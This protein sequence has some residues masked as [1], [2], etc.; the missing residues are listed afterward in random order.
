MAISSGLAK[1]SV[2]KWNCFWTTRTNALQS[3]T[4]DY[5]I[6]GRT[7]RTKKF[8]SRSG[9]GVFALA[10]QAGRRL[11]ARFGGDDDWASETGKNQHNLRDQNFGAACPYKQKLICSFLPKKHN[12]L[13]GQLLRFFLDRGMRLV[14]LH[15]AIRFKSLPYIASYIANDTAKRQQFKH[16]NVK[17]SF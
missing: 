17:K 16:D 14:K 9:L 3:S 4:L 7:N 13:L 1:T 12:V 5:F 11:F 8:Y 10:P 15:R 2:A 6:I